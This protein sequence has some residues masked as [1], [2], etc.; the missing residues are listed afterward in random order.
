MKAGKIVGGSCY[1]NGCMAVITKIGIHM[2][3]QVF[4]DTVASAILLLGSLASGGLT[5]VM[6]KPYCV[7]LQKK[8]MTYNLCDPDFYRVVDVESEEIGVEEEDNG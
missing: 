3:K 4:A 1:K 5:W 7:K 8:L 2:T 6:F